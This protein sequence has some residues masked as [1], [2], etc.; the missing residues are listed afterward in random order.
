MYKLCKTEQSARRQRELEAGLLAAMKTRR[1]EDITISELCEQMGVPRKSFYRYFSGKDGALHALLDHTMMEFD[2]FTEP[3]QPGEPRTLYKDL[4]VFF[5]F[6]LR[7]RPLLD[8]LER[9]GLSGILIERSIS[10]ASEFAFPSRLLPGEDKSTQQ[11]VVMFSVCGLMTMMLTWHH[12][13]Y[14]ESTRELA[15]VAARLLCQPLF[16]YAGE[17]I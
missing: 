11:H 13:G 3:Y 16:P 8:V 15:V 17:L 14:R 2:E 4:E 1:Y 6:W 9:S 7:R 12:G 5:L 10:Y